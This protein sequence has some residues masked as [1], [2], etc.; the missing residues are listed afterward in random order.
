MSCNEELLTLY[1]RQ[2]EYSDYLDGLQLSAQRYY[3]LTFGTILAAL[4]HIYNRTEEISVLIAIGSCVLLVIGIGTIFQ[5]GRLKAMNLEVDISIK[6]LGL[7][8]AEKA[9]AK[10]MFT[11]STKSEQI[12]PC[13]LGNDWVKSF[14]VAVGNTVCFIYLT[15]Y[16]VLKDRGIILYLLTITACI[17]IHLFIYGI[18]VFQRLK[19]K[20]ILLD[21]IHHTIILGNILKLIKYLRS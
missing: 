12:D 5:L 13:I 9:G 3:F 4:S 20:T 21:S 17:E 18:S 16:Y 7:S 6:S 15:Y 14:F 11:S 2:C 1:K 8:I 10:N 19:S